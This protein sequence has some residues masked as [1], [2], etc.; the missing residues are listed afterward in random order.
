MGHRELHLVRSTLASRVL[1]VAVAF[2]LLTS[3]AVAGPA[4][5]GQSGNGA[6]PTRAAPDMPAPK[7]VGPTIALSL[8]ES[9]FIGL[10]DNR[11]IRSAYMERIAQKFDLRVAGDRFAPRLTISSAFLARRTDSTTTTTGNFTPVATLLTPTGALFG[12]TWATV[13]SNTRGGLRSR[14]STLDLTVIQPL[15]RGA[16]TTVNT[17]PLHV[18]QIEER[19]NQL[20][21]RDTVGQT[22]TRIILAYRDLLRAQE[23]RTLADAA[24]TRARSLVAVNRALIAAGRMAAVEIVQ[25]EA[26]VALQELAVLE[27]SNRLDATRL[28]FLGLIAVDPRTDVRAADQLDATPVDVSLER[29]LPLA[30]ASRPDYLSQRLVIEQAKL[31][32]TVARNQR[33]WDLAA[34]GSVGVGHAEFAGLP[35]PSESRTAPN[36]SA[37]LQ[38]TIPLGDLSLEQGEVRA[39]TT[40]RTAEIRLEDLRQQVE[41]EVRDAVREIQTRWRQLET[42]RRARALAERSLAIERDKLQVGRSSNFQVLA[43][44]DDLRRAETQQLDALIQYL[45]ALTLLDQQLG[46]TLDT[47]QIALNS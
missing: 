2:A 6:H 30:L 26:D 28:A 13:E 27:A 41:S 9:V 4:A 45:N 12:F 39:T 17:A 18:A 19:L 32:V 20:R 7:P 5:T 37:G 42:A 1:G 22:V 44:E 3:V 40:L 14:S 24:L 10:R 33:L 23:Q 21:L 38:L 46:T 31:G 34:V 25:T 47:W 8:P 15:L 36:A 16:G 43:F 29:V 35:T 11:A